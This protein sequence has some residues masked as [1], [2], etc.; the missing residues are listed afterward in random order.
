MTPEVPGKFEKSDIFF[1]HVVQ[2]ANCAR[3]SATEPDD[4][5][6]GAAEF[7]LQRLYLLSGRMEAPLEKLLE[8]VHQ[9]VTKI[10]LNFQTERPKQRRKQLLGFQQYPPSGRHPEWPSG[11]EVSGAQLHNSGQSGYPLRARCFASSA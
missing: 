9:D 6:S 10:T 11:R 4:L 2:N 3:S 7:S 8:N 1:P 5:P